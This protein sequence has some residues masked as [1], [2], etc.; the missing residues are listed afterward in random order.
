MTDLL[1]LLAGCVWTGVG[2]FVYLRLA[3]QGNETV[4]KSQG[5]L[6]ILV[7]GPIVWIFFAVM[8][9]S[10]WKRSRRRNNQR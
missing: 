8:F 3:P 5:I 9:W 1:Y 2:P 7:C 4:A 6:L 10:M